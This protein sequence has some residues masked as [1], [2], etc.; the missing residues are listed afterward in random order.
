M[1]NLVCDTIF[2]W[3]VFRLSAAVTGVLDGD[4]DGA[5]TEVRTRAASVDKTAARIADISQI[6]AALLDAYTNPAVL[7]TLK[8]KPKPGA[9]FKPGSVSL[10]DIAASAGLYKTAPVYK[11]VDK[12]K[13]KFDSRAVS[14]D[15]TADPAD[16]KKLKT[17]PKPVKPGSKP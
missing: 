2:N 17:R 11:P 6:A 14:G 12:T 13:A 16:V 7:Q 1:V 15:K 5:E 10:D 4:R 3:F 8:I 9:A